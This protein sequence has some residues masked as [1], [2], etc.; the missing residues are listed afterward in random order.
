MDSPARTLKEGKPPVA[1]AIAPPKCLFFVELA[2]FVSSVH[3]PN[4]SEQAGRM[5]SMLVVMPSPSHNK[6]GSH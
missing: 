4:L 2:L 1:V 3:L 5:P 6:D